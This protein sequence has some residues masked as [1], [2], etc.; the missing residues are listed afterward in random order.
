MVALQG[1]TATVYR[2]K[3]GDQ[4]YAT[5]LK[6]EGQVDPHGAGFRVEDYGTD[7]GF[8]TWPFLQAFVRGVLFEYPWECT[9]RRSSGGQ[10]S[11]H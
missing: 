9:L 7:L 1:A 3:R 8:L 2:C 10:K 6:S 4:E 11:T 5:C